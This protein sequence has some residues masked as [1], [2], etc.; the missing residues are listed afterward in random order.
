MNAFGVPDDALAA[1]R[2]LAWRLMEAGRVD[3]ARAIL[4]GL[5]ELSP[6]EPWAHEALAALALRR[7]DPE[8]ALAHAAAALSES[9][10]PSAV[11]AYAQALIASGHRVKARPFLRE[12]AARAKGTPLA[13]S[14][15]A[16]LR[17]VS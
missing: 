11:F 1:A 6:S 5:A 3:R 16:L 8:A 13:I 17:D 14:A 4:V 15:G 2:Q 9:R 12:A 10:A 7:H